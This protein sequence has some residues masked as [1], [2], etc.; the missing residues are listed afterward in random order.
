[1]KY[2]LVRLAL[3]SLRSLATLRQI[4]NP[5]GTAPTLV[6]EPTAENVKCQPIAAANH[7]C[8]WH[9]NNVTCSGLYGGAVINQQNQVYNRFLSFP[10]G[11][12]AHP[13]LTLPYLGRQVATFPKAIL[14]LTPVQSTN[15]YHWLA[16]VLPRLLLI[17]QCKLPDFEQRQVL[18]HHNTR[19]YE[20]D[21]LA[22]AGVRPNQIFRF[23]PFETVAVADL[24]IA[25]FELSYSEHAFPAWKQRL[26]TDFKQQALAKIGPKSLKKV[27]LLRG[28]QRIRRLIGEERLVTLLKGQGFHIIDPQQL[29]LAEQIS[30]LAGAQVIVALH[31][32]ALTN[33][34]FCAE[35]T[36]VLE[37]RSTDKPPE[38]FSAIADTYKLRFASISIPPEKVVAAPNLANKQN[39][40][41]TEEAINE[42]LA[43]LTAWSGLVKTDSALR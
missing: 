23:K 18:L 2:E 20:T 38:F 10:W 40:I 17:K 25:D 39:L 32:A 33:I 4:G 15:Y 1:M 13:T 34:I 9:L 37:L 42:L 14:L 36:F 3:K 11:N 19:T 27:Y 28:M 6:Q 26:L 41:L 7:L 22:I 35:G 8:V 21:T 29:T 16:D 12:S 31:G 24:V 5:A 30:T 43:Q